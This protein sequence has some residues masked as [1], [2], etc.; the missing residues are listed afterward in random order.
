V[1][2]VFP[3]SPDQIGVQSGLILPYFVSPFR[4]TGLPAGRQGLGVAPLPHSV[5]QGKLFSISLE[6][7]YPE[8]SEG[9]AGWVIGPIPFPPLL[10]YESTILNCSFFVNLF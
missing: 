2:C 5:R 10:I 1:L 4:R 3:S 8:R 9:V 7:V 6:R